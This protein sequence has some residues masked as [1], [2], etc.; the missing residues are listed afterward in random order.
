[1]RG[2]KRRGSYRT[3]EGG[4]SSA[5]RDSSDMSDSGGEEEEEDE[6]EEEEE[7]EM[8]SQGVSS[9]G[10]A[11]AIREK[12]DMPSDEEDDVDSD[13][14]GL[15]ANADNMTPA[16]IEATVQ[17]EKKMARER[18]KELEEQGR[19]RKRIAD[20]LGKSR[21]PQK[22]AIIARKKMRTPLAVAKR[23]GA[24]VASVVGNEARELAHEAVDM[25]TPEAVRA[26]RKRAK[27][28]VRL[29]EAEQEMSNLYERLAHARREQKEKL[30]L[31]FTSWKKRKA[32]LEKL[33]PTDEIK[34][35]LFSDER[36][37]KREAELEHYRLRVEAD[38]NAKEAAEKLETEKRSSARKRRRDEHREFLV[39]HWEKQGPK[40]I[41]EA[42]QATSRRKAEAGRR[43]AAGREP[44]AMEAKA[45]ERARIEDQEM[46]PAISD[47]TPGL[48]LFGVGENGDIDDENIGSG[49]ALFIPS[50]AAAER[51]EVWQELNA[52]ESEVARAQDEYNTAQEEVKGF[53]QELQVILTRRQVA[54]TDLEQLSQERAQAARRVL[55]AGSE[56][57]D[58]EQGA[59]HLR[60]ERMSTLRS[61]LRVAHERFVRVSDAKRGSEACA[62]KLAQRLAILRERAR[63]K[64]EAVE[65][66]YGSGG[67]LPVIVGHSITRTLGAHAAPRE[68]LEEVR[69]RSQIELMKD[70]AKE[71]TVFHRAVGRAS[72]QNWK[73]GLE[74]QMEED[75]MQGLLTRLKSA[76]ERLKRADGES[77]RESLVNAINLFHAAGGSKLLNP[78]DVRHEGLLTWWRYRDT[79]RSENVEAWGPADARSTIFNEK[80]ENI[81][82]DLQFGVSLAHGAFSGRIEGSVPLPRHGLWAIRLTVTRRNPLSEGGDKTDW[83]SLRLGTSVKSLTS[84]GNIC[85]V[86]NDELGEVR[87]FITFTVRSSALAYQ[88]SFS[89]SSIDGEAHMCVEVG[90]YETYVLAPLEVHPHG[91]VL[92]S[93]VKT[94]RVEAAA[95]EHRA[96]RILEDLVAAESSSSSTWDSKC[97]HETPQRF[98]RE[99][100]IR[101]AREEL[102]ALASLEGPRSMTVSDTAVL[103]SLPPK[104]RAS[105]EAYVR[106]KQMKAKPLVD[107]ATGLVGSR[108]HVLNTAANIWQPMLVLGANISWVENGIILRVRHTVALA[109]HS[110]WER[111]DSQEVEIDL[112]QVRWAP[113]APASDSAK[114]PLL[115]STERAANAEEVEA[116]PTAASIITSRRQS[117]DMTLGMARRRA[118]SMV[119]ASTR[120]ECSRVL[121]DPPIVL[122]EELKALEPRGCSDA[123][124]ARRTSESVWVSQRVQ[125]ETS[126]EELKWRRKAQDLAHRRRLEDSSLQRVS[127]RRLR[128]ASA[129]LAAFSTSRESSFAVASRP[130]SVL[131]APP[132][133]PRFH[134]ALP[135][136]M[137]DRCMHLRTRN[138]G[139]A[140]DHGE[141]C[142]ECGHEVSA[143]HEDLAQLAGIGY[144]DDP[145][146]ANAVQRHRL[147]EGTYI[148]PWGAAATGNGL[149]A[150]EQERIR[151]EKERRVLISEYDVEF[152]DLEDPENIY[153]FDRRHRRHLQGARVLRQG[154][155]WTEDELLALDA[156]AEEL[157][158]LKSTNGS[159]PMSY[160]SY[161]ARRRARWLDFVNQASRIMQN[162][163]RIAILRKDRMKL[164]RMR[165][166]NDGLL[167]QICKDR[168]SLNRDLA[169]IGCE[170]SE[171]DRMLALRGE[172]QEALTHWQVALERAKMA[173]DEAQLALA[174]KDLLRD[175][176]NADMRAASDCLKEALQQR[177]L[178]GSRRD[179][180][181]LRVEELHREIE[182]ACS[183]MEI[184]AKEESKLSMAERGNIVIT[185]FGRGTVSVYRKEDDIVVTELGFGRPPVVAYLNLERLW[186][187]EK[188]RAA[189][190]LTSMAAEDMAAHAVWKG[191]RSR[192]RAEE[193]QMS[194][195]EVEM[196]AW[197]DLENRKEAA[198]LLSREIVERAKAD[199][200]HMLSL[201]SV[202]RQRET[203]V[204]NKLAKR[205]SDP[206]RPRSEAGSTRRSPFKRLANVWHA[207][208][209]RLAFDEEFL[210]ARMAAAEVAAE[211]QLARASDAMT[212]EGILT[213]VIA[214]FVSSF[215][216][217]VAEIEI[218]TSIHAR[219][220][221]ERT[222]GMY[223]SNDHG[224]R[225]LSFFAYQA[226]SSG[227]HARIATALQRV[228][229]LIIK[230]A[231]EKQRRAREAEAAREMAEN[232]R[233]RFER[234][235]DRAHSAAMCTEMAAVEASLRSFYAEEQR[236]LVQERRDMRAADQESRRM[237]MH[238][239]KLRQMTILNQRSQAI[240]S[241]GKRLQDTIQTSTATTR[242]SRREEVKI[243]K[244]QQRREAAERS[245]M[246][247]EDAL[248]R[249]E[250]RM[251]RSWMKRKRDHELRMERIALALK[252][253]LAGAGASLGEGSDDT[254]SL[255]A[256]DYASSEESDPS[257][258]DIDFAAWA[259]LYCPEA[260]AGCCHDEDLLLGEGT[261]SIAD[262]LMDGATEV[263]FEQFAAIAGPTSSSF[264][265][266]A[267]SSSRGTRMRS[268]LRTRSSGTSSSL[269]SSSVGEQGS[270]GGSFAAAAVGGAEADDNDDDDDE[271][272]DG[273]LSISNSFLER[274]V[275][276]L[277]RRLMRRAAR[278][279]FRVVKKRRLIHD[280]KVSEERCAAIAISAL[281]DE[282]ELEAVQAEV[283]WILLDKNVRAAEVELKRAVESFRI[284]DL[285]CQRRALEEVS[286]REAAARASS[287]H[288]E[289]IR[290]SDEAHNWLDE[291]TA[292]EHRAKKWRDRVLSGTKYFQGRSLA[293]H[294]QSW[295][296]DW[297]RPKL[298]DRYFRCI[299]D[300]IVVD[301][302]LIGRERSALCV[303]ESLGRNDAAIASKE[304][305][306]TALRRELRLLTLL[307]LRR[308]EL[309]SRV[310][311]ANR[312]RVLREA[313]GGWTRLH[314]SLRGARDSF[315][316][317]YQLLLNEAQLDACRKPV[318][319]L[320]TASHAPSHTAPTMLQTYKD[321]HAQC[322][323][324]SA[325]YLPAQN[326]DLSCTYHTGSFIVACPSSCPG[327]TPAC[328]THRVRRWT[329][330]DSREGGVGGSGGC[331]R[332]SHVPSTDQMDARVREVEARQKSKL[333]ELDE[334]LKSISEIKGSLEREGRMAAKAQWRKMEDEL[335]E[336]RSYISV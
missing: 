30:A 2:A 276:L 85:N 239:A 184:R 47:R 168:E 258:M 9:S 46:S 229:E 331:A 54:E 69:I 74:L 60:A 6:E 248:S 116:L 324:C 93:Y 271:N 95:P 15:W 37:R 38:M 125:K 310:F 118:I 186:L 68:L 300:A 270:G 33:K 307:N 298:H 55:L 79:G 57:Q 135:P 11:V 94:L 197:Q 315:K 24:V 223:L 147:N 274:H 19:H 4:K 17:L 91:V 243:Q 39:G 115:P 89:S 195:E 185:P 41:E 31:E 14:F 36:E 283:Q 3:K 51:E 323:N 18:K 131:K 114:D 176:A 261:S 162:A 170:L 182:S 214:E 83:I 213:D 305:Q 53:D 209:L 266:A 171:C 260:G 281:R 166:E 241:S 219:E 210:R 132:P 199:A 238:L 102:D 246:E 237:E 290:V 313:L 242:E 328:M 314:L 122:L 299:V 295:E 25:F 5:S 225:R 150:V 291:C 204:M 160:R 280:L 262:D 193:W 263:S 326:T 296:T 211:R 273:D 329:C 284:I 278:A 42:K 333:D 61:A 178:R 208:K 332:R 196:R 92:S 34:Q 72:L 44:S 194:V 240:G 43:W 35:E 112:A 250:N 120:A 319:T 249:V 98:D 167:L 234:A 252:K 130:S 90:A 325:W 334:K 226:L 142:V 124:E 32:E 297:V 27:Y 187:V 29:A 140:Y 257:C 200:P 255:I 133:I 289:R 322:R 105:A 254:M 165:L 293:G 78:V 282:A 146:M 180:L 49:S 251:F 216:A 163:S 253:S 264:D 311:G 129:P 141:R 7:D 285:H 20:L 12:K 154:V 321:M 212:Q 56:A 189:A 220:A 63:R 288:D 164:E 287:M 77:V 265:M 198:A 10:G 155:Q 228:Q 327:V 272:H 302:E 203:W 117:Q 82:Q 174:G 119:A 21:L 48:G 279:A 286:A 88:F 153:N 111:A 159:A 232:H 259:G 201:R 143:S 169:V 128:A 144:L 316:M 308:S 59:N 145:E 96:F 336:E 175:M 126:D 191:D 221:A 13:P 218:D 215:I 149:G 277:R 190:E 207:R 45:R 222:S 16:E 230:I 192:A 179:S 236:I 103:S 64:R 70:Q 294:W 123:D 22:E 81:S 275:E 137:P 87:H 231:K 73:T 97:L 335:A 247:A 152:Y 71:A 206:N 330:C 50:K 108:I 244:V 80:N 109:D 158:W 65:G 304:K 227:W 138:W 188:A 233:A 26:Q 306:G 268:M 256:P 235:E 183:K 62:L 84:A 317:D 75:E 161:D 181:Q 320:P 148:A 269:S 86:V 106:R 40:L 156:G 139:A 217:E 245:A 127:N 121:R 110:N 100:F 202:C 301:A 23:V 172:A 58:M 134:L 303:Q 28:I 66:P 107:A 8:A 312:R 113:A 177:L 101:L 224:G 76:T 309:C 205:V 1:M 52:L 292:N 157:A 173:A 136:A 104:V 267:E 67:T 99:I 318:G 151:L